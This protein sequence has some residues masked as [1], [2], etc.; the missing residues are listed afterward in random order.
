MGVS[1][2]FLALSCLSTDIPWCGCKIPVFSSP[3]GHSYSVAELSICF[4]ICLA[5]QLTDRTLEMHT[6]EW[7]KVSS[8][9]YEVRGKTLGIV[10]YGHIGSQLGVLA[11]SI[12]MRVIFY[13]IATVLPMGRNQ[14]Q[15]SLAA[16]LPV[17]DF[18][19]VC[20][21]PTDE[22][23]KFIGPN[24][25]RQMKKGS[26]IVNTS[27]GDAIDLDAVAEAL[28][29]KHLAGAA[30]DVFPKTPLSNSTTFQH[31][32][33][34]LKNV[35]MVPNLGDATQ[36]AHERVGHD[37]ANSIARFLN[38]GASVGAVNFPSIQTWALKPGTRRI[39]NMHRN[40]RGVLKEIDYILSA[41]N[42]G[43]QVLETNGKLGYLIADVNTEEVTTEIVAQLALL[44]NTIRSRIL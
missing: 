20:V 26:Y 30:F 17:S 36:Q 25:I 38:E 23:R 32:F 44:S 37:V 14:P 12:G 39:L 7:N 2:I 35:I 1:D 19:A 15:A 27:Y 41:Y 13:D 4:I 10:G 40:V 3:Y 22:N 24:E 42:V 33:S 18:V 9:C 28:K 21:S 16:L 5:R 8:N 34:G 43:K 11:E 31:P 29:S 6:S